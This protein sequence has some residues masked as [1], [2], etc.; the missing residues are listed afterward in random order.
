MDETIGALV[1]FAGAAFG[2]LFVL[3]VGNEICL[4]LRTAREARAWRSK[5]PIVVAD[6]VVRGDDDDDL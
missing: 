1:F 2:G 6:N 3:V 5:D 4:R